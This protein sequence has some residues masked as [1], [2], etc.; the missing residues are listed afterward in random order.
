MK[1]D[2]KTV[3]FLE[4]LLFLLFRFHVDAYVCT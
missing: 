4:N 3:L 2:Y 1:N